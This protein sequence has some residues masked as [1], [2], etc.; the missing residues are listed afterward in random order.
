MKNV[1][2][3]LMCLFSVCFALQ[4]NSGI[5]EGGDNGDTNQKRNPDK[6]FDVI[7]DAGVPLPR[8]FIPGST[9]ITGYNLDTTVEVVFESTLGDVTISIVD[10]SG[11]VVYTTVVNTAASPDSEWVFNKDVLTSGIYKIEFEYLMGRTSYGYFE[12]Q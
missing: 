12:V 10:N 5:L 2:F 6:I 11:T 3:L 4:A 1:K 9:L 8:S 7:D